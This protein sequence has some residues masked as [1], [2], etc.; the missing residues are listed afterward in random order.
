MTLSIV[1]ERLLEL[2]VVLIG[3][4]WVALGAALV[5]ASASRGPAYT[6]YARRGQTAGTATG[7]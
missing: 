6:P 4:L 5:R 2:S 3:L 7:P 1:E